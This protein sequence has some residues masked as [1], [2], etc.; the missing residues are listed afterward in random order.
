MPKPKLPEYYSEYRVIVSSSGQTEG[1]ALHNHK[2]N[3]SYHKRW[4]KGVLTEE[5]ETSRDTYEGHTSIT[6]VLIYSK[7]NRDEGTDKRD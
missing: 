5:S 6:T 3:L 1:Q 4:I 7:G 2:L